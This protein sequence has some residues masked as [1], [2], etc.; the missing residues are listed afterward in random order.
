[1]QG[2]SGFVPRYFP[3]TVPA[4]PPPYAAAEPRP[5]SPSET[6]PL[7]YDDISPHL[8]GDEPYEDVPPSFVVAIASPEPPLLA[9]RFKHSSCS[10]T[11]D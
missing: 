10:P 7:S 3:G 1:M 5:F 2:P 6:T 9:V 8:D 4:P 11:C